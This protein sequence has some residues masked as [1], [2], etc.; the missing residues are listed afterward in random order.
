M[1]CNH[2]ISEVKYSMY[3]VKETLSLFAD[4]YAVTSAAERGFGS[5]YESV[6]NIVYNHFSRSCRHR[7]SQYLTAQVVDSDGRE[8][9]RTES[10]FYHYLCSLEWVPAYR[11]L[12][13]EQQERNY[14]RP[15]SVYL[16]SPEVTNLLGTHV[17]YVDINPSEFSRA[18]GKI[19]CLFRCRSLLSIAVII[20][21]HVSAADYFDIR[22][23]LL[24]LSPL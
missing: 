24:L 16:S 11:P 4:I 17:S 23:N 14:L 19:N 15:N 7:Y 12:E 18:I 20:G 3:L 5:L 6:P 2:R 22:D 10:S 8:L 9:K 13:G 21:Y 1:N